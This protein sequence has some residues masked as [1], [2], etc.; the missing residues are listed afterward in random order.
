MSDTVF[1]Y[2]I[3]G[4]SGGVLS[5]KN[6]SINISACSF[7]NNNASRKGGALTVYTNSHLMILNST[8]MHNAASDSGRAL[9]L[10]ETSKSIIAN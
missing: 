4:R 1:G 7:T 8:L 10:A 2:S 6:S 5:A 9:Y 3:S